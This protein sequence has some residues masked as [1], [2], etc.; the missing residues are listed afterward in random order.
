MSF[1]KDIEELNRLI[2]SVIDRATMS[3]SSVRSISH[4]SND[5]LIGIRDMMILLD[6]TKDLLENWAR[7]LDMVPEMDA[8]LDRII[9]SNEELKE[10]LKNEKKVTAKEK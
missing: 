2:D 5:D 9:K 7:V 4:M 6:K 10:E 3:S 1:K 8:K